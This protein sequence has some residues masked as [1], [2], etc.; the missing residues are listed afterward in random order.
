[1]HLIYQYQP[2]SRTS[3]FSVHAAFTTF[4]SQCPFSG[5]VLV[6]T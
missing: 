1:M 3:L 2:A 5:I 4:F 6:P